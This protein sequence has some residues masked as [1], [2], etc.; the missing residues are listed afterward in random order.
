M[1]VWVGIGGWV[2]FLVAK[3]PTNRQNVST[4]QIWEEH[5]TCFH[6]E[7]EAA[8]RVCYLSQSQYFPSGLN[9]P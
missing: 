7:T 1:S 9:S 5:C 2:C 6:T 8:D 4:R 3:H